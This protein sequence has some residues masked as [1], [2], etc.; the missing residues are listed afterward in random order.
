MIIMVNGE[1][2]NVPDENYGNY[3]SEE[4]IIGS[5]ID[6]K[7]LYR[8]VITDTFGDIGVWKYPYRFSESITV[9]KL[10]AIVFSTSGAVA[11]LPNIDVSNNLRTLA[12]YNT[13]RITIYTDNDKHANQPFT[14]IIEYT[15]D[16]D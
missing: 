4:T 16:S 11:Q 10:E 6:G 9:C 7:P 8:R 12:N 5:W 14:L 15:K 3:K 1:S 2:V 13:G